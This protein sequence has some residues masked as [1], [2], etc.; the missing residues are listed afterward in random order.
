MLGQMSNAKP[1]ENSKRK[2]RC[3]CFQKILPIQ[4]SDDLIVVLFY[5]I[6]YSTSCIF[7]SLVNA[8]VRLHNPNP[9]PVGELE[10]I[11]LV[12]NCCLTLDFGKICLELEPINHQFCF[13]S[14]YLYFSDFPHP[15]FFFYFFE[16]RLMSTRIELRSKAGQDRSLK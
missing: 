7:A 1:S 4:S 10:E 16:L 15:F 2:S 3:S 13:F 6:S 12:D 8:F 5:T 14:F 11:C 9:I